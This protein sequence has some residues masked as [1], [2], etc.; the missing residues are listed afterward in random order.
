MRSL[1]FG[2][3]SK[4]LLLRRPRSRCRCLS[5]LSLAFAFACQQPLLGD[6]AAEVDSGR[7][8]TNR[9]Q[10]QQQ[11]QRTCESGY[12]GVAAGPPHKQLG[13]GMLP[14]QNRLIP[15]I[16]IQIFGHL[17]RRLIAIARIPVRRL[18]NDRDQVAGNV[19]GKLGTRRDFRATDLP[20]QLDALL[21]VKG[22]L[23][24]EH[25]VQRQSQ[26][27]DVAAHIRPTFDHLRRQ[28]TER[29][30]NVARIRQLAIPNF[31]QAEIGDPHIAIGSY[32]EIRGLDVA[33][34][35]AALVR[36]LQRVSDLPPQGTNVLPVG[37]I[38]VAPRERSRSLLRRS[39]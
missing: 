27:V 23:E 4:R 31:R 10:D 8:R 5:R 2:D 28:I 14:S 18:A 30:E 15:Q 26:R 7:C 1:Q 17:S 34:Q 12:R 9:H 19:R 25:F 35:N 38:P 20:Q 13:P 11:R 3:A 21:G 22:A 24:R 29:A 36:M 16:A 37:L 32:Q 33:M 39:R 6:Q